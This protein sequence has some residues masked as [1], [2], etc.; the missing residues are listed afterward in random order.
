LKESNSFGQWFTY[1]LHFWM[2]VFRFWNFIPG[3]YNFSMQGIKGIPI[4]LTLAKASGAMGWVYCSFI[5]MRGS[6]VEMVFTASFAS[7]ERFVRQWQD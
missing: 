5:C 1:G 2:V 3:I 6:S 7:D 4:A